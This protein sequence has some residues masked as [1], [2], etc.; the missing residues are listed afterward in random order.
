MRLLA[1]TLGALLVSTGLVLAQ[2]T[3]KGG[4]VFTDTP[5]SSTTLSG[6]ASTGGSVT[7]Y[8]GTTYQMATPITAT[9]FGYEHNIHQAPLKETGGGVSIYRALDGYVEML[10]GNPILHITKLY[11]VKETGGETVGPPVDSENVDL[12]LS[13]NWTEVPCRKATTTK[14]KSVKHKKAYP[15]NRTTTYVPP[16]TQCRYKAPGND[17]GGPCLPRE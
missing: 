4:L 9:I 12:M 11:Y 13:N 16:N 14:T 2:T 7:C 6:G 8:T 3:L 5:P 10:Q 17:L 1:W 15:P